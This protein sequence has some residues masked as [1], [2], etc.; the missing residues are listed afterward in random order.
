MT[1]FFNSMWIHHLFFSLITQQTSQ[2]TEI[3][4]SEINIDI[5]FIYST[6]SSYIFNID[7]E[8][9]ISRR[10]IEIFFPFHHPVQLI[11]KKTFCESPDM[12]LDIFVIS[13]RCRA[14]SSREWE[15]KKKICSF[16]RARHRHIYL[17]LISILI[18]SCA[19]RSTQ[20]SK[21]NIFFSIKILLS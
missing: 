7:D 15:K 2:S 13:F 6:P 8:I 4:F 3:I 17:W 19:G 10:K 21:G 1:K 16:W 14:N 5:L 18:S 9:R 20:S 12:R 11:K